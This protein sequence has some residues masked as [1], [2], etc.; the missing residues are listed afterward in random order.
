MVMPSPILIRG[1]N[2]ADRFNSTNSASPY[3]AGVTFPDVNVRDWYCH[4]KSATAYITAFTTYKDQLFT[5]A[6]SSFVFTSAES[7]T[8]KTGGT[9]TSGTVGIVST[10]SSGTSTPT[11]TPESAGS[12]APIGAI[13]G[14]AVG[15]FAVLAAVAALIFFFCRRQKKKAVVAEQQPA[16]QQAYAPPAQPPMQGYNN[17]AYPP[18]YNANY[19]NAG[20]APY[21]PEYNNDG[22]NSF[23]APPMQKVVPTSPTTT[24]PTSPAP[25]SMMMRGSEPTSPSGWDAQQ[26]GRVSGYYDVGV[27]PGSQGTPPQ[28]H[29][30]PINRNSQA[31]TQFVHEIGGS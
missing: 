27:S 14:G 31:P 21:A 7:S 23:Y 28:G 22:R 13:V 5:T 16:M 19:P 11:P 1:R 8:T 29:G 9:T 6:F 2:Q 10:P 3:C 12:S 30:I 26:Q 18:N 15:G 17:G 4:S 24:A 20:L 25:H